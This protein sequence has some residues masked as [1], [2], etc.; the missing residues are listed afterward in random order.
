LMLA[1]FF[2]CKDEKKKFNDVTYEEQKETLEQK[3]RKNPLHFLKVEGDYNKNIIGQTVV[4]MKIIN[5]ASLVSYK[6][7]RVKMLFYDKE[8][9]VFENHEEIFEKQIKPGDYSKLKS[10][11]F[12]QR[13][14]DSI[15]LSIMSAV[16]VE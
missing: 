12:A 7:I 9:K 5:K 1:C 4:K 11:Y 8:G 3:E 2:S 13:R 14:T 16:D 15:A 6:N 10:K